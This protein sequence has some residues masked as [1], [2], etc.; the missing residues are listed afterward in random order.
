MRVYTY[1]KNTIPIALGGAIFLSLAI[2]LALP[3]S[4]KPPTPKPIEQTMAKPS[5]ETKP[6]QEVKVKMP[7]KKMVVGLCFSEDLTRVV[8]IKKERPDWQK[9]L[10]NG[11]GGKL[12]K[13]ETPLTA[14]IREFEEEA[15]VKTTPEDWQQFAQMKGAGWQVTYFR[16]FNNAYVDSVK[17][18]TDETVVVSE[19][20]FDM[21]SDLGV[22]NLHWL[23]G[24]ALDD[25]QPRISTTIT[26]RPENFDPEK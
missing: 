12:E 14:I 25:D 13:G 6:I 3:L 2:V 4:G 17:T 18:K 8:L 21:L 10:L 16:C 24:L 20:S 7:I 9:G 19:V 15:G 11:V 23:V 5:L 22:S 26:Y 1:G